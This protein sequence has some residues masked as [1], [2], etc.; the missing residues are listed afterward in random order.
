M[1]EDIT[2]GKHYNYYPY[3]AGGAD[4]LNVPPMLFVDG[5]SGVACS[6]KGT[7]FPVPM[8][9][10]ASFDTELE[11]KV[12][13]AIAREIRAY[14]GNLFG[15]VCINLPYHPGWE[16]S[17]ETYGEES[18]ALGQMGSALVRGIQDEHVVACIRHF[19]FNSMEISR[20]NVDMDCA[21]RTER[22]VFLPHFKDCIDVGAACAMSSYNLYQGMYCGHNN[23][24][25]LPKSAVDLPQINWETKS[26][27][28]DYY[29]GYARLE[30]LEIAPLLP[31][32]F[33]LSYTTFAYNDAEFKTDG[34]NVI[35]SC[36]VTN[37]GDVQGKEAVQ[38]YIGF[39]NS[40]W[41]DQSN[42]F[43]GFQKWN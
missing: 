1:L 27:Y 43:E 41:I 23:Y 22:E 4:A 13:T 6:D 25:V 21:R 40:H 2:S 38:L 30:K 24:L 35:A 11:E 12:G 37:T 28:Y 7:C 19:A 14:G 31:Y 17:Q 16:R 15:G 5:G 10:G 34:A 32:G 39:K 3:P 26:Q 36:A 8:C 33:G 29:H 9:R 18:F 42:Y 20:F